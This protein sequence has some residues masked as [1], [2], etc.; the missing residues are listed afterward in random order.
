MGSRW[1]TVRGDRGFTVEYHPIPSARAT[2]PGELK[3]TL[4]SLKPNLDG[5]TKKV[6]L[7]TITQCIFLKESEAN[8]CSYDDIKL[9]ASFLD[10]PDE[11]IKIEALN[12]LNAFTTIWKF[13][14]KIQAEEQEL[15]LEQ[16]YVPK[17][18]ELVVNN[19]NGNLHFAGL[20]L[21]NGLDITEQTHPTLSK[22]IPNFMDILLMSDA[23]AKVQV[24][25][26]LSTMAQKED[27]LFSILNCQVPAEFL[28]HFQPSL[29][30]NL[31]YEMLVFVERLNEGRLTPQYQSMHKQYKSLS[32][33]EI[34]FGENSR[35]SDNL[36]AL[37][38]HPEEEVQVQA[39]KV[40]LSL[41][42]NKEESRIISSLPFGASISSRPNEPALGNLPFSPSRVSSPATN[43][44]IIHTS[45]SGSQFDYF[46]NSFQPLQGTDDSSRG[47]YPLES[48]GGQNNFPVPDTSSISSHTASATGHAPNSVPVSDTSS[49]SSHTASATGH[50]PNSVPVSDTSSISS[51]TA[52]ATG[53]APNSFPVS[54]TSSISSHTASV[55]G[56]SPNRVPVRDTSSI[57]S[58]TASTTGHASNSVPVRDT[59]SISSHT[60]SVIGH[61]P[62]SVHVLDTSSISSHTASAIGHAPNSV[63]VCD[64]SSISSHTAS[65]IGHTANSVPVRD[66]S[67]ISSHT[68]STT[69]HTPNSVPVRDTSSI[70]SH[71]ASAIGHTPSSVSVRDPMDSFH[72]VA[73]AFSDED[74]GNC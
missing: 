65:V 22:L 17:I 20:R 2:I 72:A 6:A 8:S 45:C 61:A 41:R 19:W 44:V 73:N 52:S 54:D 74:D 68:A 32:L 18:T 50:A 58:H 71:P 67:S 46:G 47:F 43:N 56:H 63:P 11:V 42:L 60:A 53:H 14:V 36:L 70:S 31:L 40:T 25:K 3:R 15:L 5:S 66:T 27:M 13:K 57:S 59:S 21:V 35:L 7:H 48:T 69:G 34:L 28:S 62:S 23:L 33:H 29:P 37:I 12:A 64:T 1:H 55:T 10:D 51:H 26:L 16:E 4:Q 38:I 9:V 39:C 24:L 49:I 30:G